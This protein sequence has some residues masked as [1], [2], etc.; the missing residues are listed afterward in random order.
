MAQPRWSSLITPQPPSHRLNPDS[1]LWLRPTRFRQPTESPPPAI[2]CPAPI[3]GLLPAER[4]I[5]PTPVPYF[6][7]YFRFC[8]FPA[9][10]CLCR[11]FGISR[12]F[13]LTRATALFLDDDDDVRSLTGGTPWRHKPFRSPAF[14]GSVTRVRSPDDSAPPARGQFAIRYS[15]F[16]VAQQKTPLSFTDHCSSS[17]I[18]IQTLP[19]SPSGG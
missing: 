9:F 15:F 7:A 17:S 5:P 18:S 14:S 6:L 10:T 2:R 11:P 8:Y 13:R 4:L 3:K 12:V 19:S 1:T 16:I